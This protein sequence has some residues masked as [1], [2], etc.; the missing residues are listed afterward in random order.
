[1]NSYDF[2]F[3]YLFKYIQSIKKLYV[4]FVCQEKMVSWTTF[5]ASN[6][7]HTQT[8]IHTYIV[9]IILNKQV[10]KYYAYLYLTLTIFLYIFLA[11]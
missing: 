9:S 10:F 7:D 11:K 1:M 5:L 8:C 3:C 2:K 4:V 6:F